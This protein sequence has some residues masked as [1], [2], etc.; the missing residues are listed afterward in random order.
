MTKSYDIDLAKEELWEAV[1]QFI[2][3][4]RISCAESI[5]QTDRVIQNAYAFIEELCEIVG[6]YEDPDDVD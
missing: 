3:E 2:D 4:H 5:Y 6:Y 1:T